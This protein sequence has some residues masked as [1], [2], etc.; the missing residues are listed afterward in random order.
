MRCL[1]SILHRVPAES[2]SAGAGGNAGRRGQ[3]ALEYI[4]LVGGAILFV[5]LVI[6]IIR[7]GVI[8]QIGGHV[9]NQ[10]SGLFNYLHQF[11]Q[12]D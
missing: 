8:P 6:A 7:A 11:M 4:I 5:I 12:G 3:G 9:T 10:T 1:H 2:G